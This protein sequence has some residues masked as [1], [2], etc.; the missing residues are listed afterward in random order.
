MG[1]FVVCGGMDVLNGLFATAGQQALEARLAE[2]VAARSALSNEIANVDTP[3]YSGAGAI[4][5]AN[6]LQTSLDQQLGVRARAGSAG[7]LV[8]TAAAGGVGGSSGAVTPDGNSVGL[9]AVMV[10]LAQ[11]D[12]YYQAVTEQLNL[13]YGQ[14]TTAIDQGGA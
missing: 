8:S 1:F 4:A 12:L 9:D 11:Q 2:L 6:S 13:R 3:G 5:F 14:M 10:Q 7:H